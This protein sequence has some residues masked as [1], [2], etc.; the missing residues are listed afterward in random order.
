[1]RYT[2]IAQFYVRSCAQPRLTK[3]FTMLNTVNW[4]S[5]LDTAYVAA[6]ATQRL[7]WQQAERERLRVVVG[8]GSASDAGTIAHFLLYAHAKTSSRKSCA[9]A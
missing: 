6:S 8:L 3:Q 9:L 1:M 2:V 5:V 4:D 7:R